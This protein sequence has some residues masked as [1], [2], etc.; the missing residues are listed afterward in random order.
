M[1]KELKKLKEKHSRLLELLN[2]EN[3]NENEIIESQ[4]LLNDYPERF[5]PNLGLVEANGV[6]SFKEQMKE[7][8]KRLNESFLEYMVFPTLLN[9]D[10]MKLP[11][12]RE[13]DKDLCTY[14]LGLFE[15]YKSLILDAEKMFNISFNIEREI[16]TICDSIIKS[17]NQYFRGHPSFAYTNLVDGIN[18]IESHFQRFLSG[19][20]KIPSQ[21]YRMRKTDGINSIFKPGE[22]SHIPFD[23]RHLIATQRYSIPGLPCLYLGS[24]PYIC[25]EELERP[26]LENTQTAIISAK[27]QKIKILDFGLRP[28]DFNEVML[29]EFKKSKNIKYTQKEFNDLKN[30]LICW[31]L[32]AASSIQVNYKNGTFKPEYI[33]PQLVLQWITSTH[34]YDGIRYFS[35]KEQCQQNSIHLIHN[36][37]FPVKTHD[38]ISGHCPSLRRLF[39]ISHGVPWQLYKLHPIPTQGEK[40]GSFSL[41]ENLDPILYNQTEFGK[42]ETYLLDN[43]YCE[44]LIEYDCFLSSHVAEKAKTFF[45]NNKAQIEEALEYVFNE[46]KNIKGPINTKPQNWSIEF[47]KDHIKIKYTVIGDTIVILEDD[48]TILHYFTKYLMGKL[49][50]VLPNGIG[51]FEYKRI[52]K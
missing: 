13:A 23:K 18:K 24:T 39:A 43:T 41:M 20:N 21:L 50:L 8:G 29:R 14:L 34:E 48:L 30:Y 26:L 40:W 31:P 10:V 1:L 25:W 49:N 6:P 37:V 46:F 4:F 5:N 3:L 38:V 36:Y 51:A 27:N 11:K 32:L 22:M 19:D 42:F 9:S 45:I 47:L 17:I 35:V 16:N 44:T 28:S 7:H 33:I 52:I 12:K 15:T 2:K